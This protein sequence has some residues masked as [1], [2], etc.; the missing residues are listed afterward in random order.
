WENQGNLLFA[1]HL[2]SSNIA[3]ATSV[4]AADVDGDLDMDIL[5]TAG[6]AFDVLWWENDGNQSFTK[7]LVDGQF[8]WTMVVQGADLDGDEDVDI[9]ATAYHGD[10]V[11]WWESKKGEIVLDADKQTLSEIAGGYIKFTLAAGI[12]N[13][14]R[15][16]LLLGSISGS[17][18]G[19]PLPGGHATLPLNWDGFTDVMLLLINSFYLTDFLGTLD[20]SGMGT[21]KLYAPPMPGM[22]GTTLHFAYTL[23]NPF[24][25]VSDALAVEVLP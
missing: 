2:V 10:R 18:P 14:D 24:D 5:G 3:G 17:D 19:F 12:N 22:A 4:Y 13:K 21:A 16:Y 20:G 11:T 1:E 8:N 6:I 15:D 7:H 9:V 23:G 25:V